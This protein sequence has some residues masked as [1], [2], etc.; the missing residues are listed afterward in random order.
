MRGFL[1]TDIQELGLKKHGILLFSLTTANPAEIL[2]N[3]FSF[4]SQFLK[5]NKRPNCSG[6]LVGMIQFKKK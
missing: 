6:L 4:L 3:F 5:K 1:D 2:I